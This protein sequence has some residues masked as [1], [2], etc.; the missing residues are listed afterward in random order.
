MT[1]ATYHPS[2]AWPPLQPLVSIPWRRI[3]HTGAVWFAFAV[4]FAYAAGGK[5]RYHVD[6]VILGR[7][8]RAVMNSPDY[9]RTIQ[10]RHFSRYNVTQL[11]KLAR[12]R[13]GSA[14][15]IGGRRISAARRDDLI[16]AIVGA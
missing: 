7:K 4:L 10:T 3:V 6:S 14:A 5:F 1:T 13:L 2:P 11:R 9:V 15:R 12:Q 8:L 16:N